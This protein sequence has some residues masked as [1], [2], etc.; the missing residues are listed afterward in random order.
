VPFGPENDQ[1]DWFIFI[2]K[3][4]WKEKV[5]VSE[6][7]IEVSS[8]CNCKTFKKENVDAHSLER[9]WKYP[10]TLKNKI[11]L[12]KILRSDKDYSS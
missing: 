1:K 5:P 7:I 4:K 12:M 3:K 11:V 10:R 6:F 2:P 8:R 9:H